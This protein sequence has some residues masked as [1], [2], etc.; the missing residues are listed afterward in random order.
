[1]VCAYVRLNLIGLKRKMKSDR[2]ERT[3]EEKPLCEMLWKLDPNFGYCFYVSVMAR[4]FGIT[5]GD[6]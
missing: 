1:M 6:I 2:K 3:K 4:D 5:K